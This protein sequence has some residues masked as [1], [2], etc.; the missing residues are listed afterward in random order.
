[1]TETASSVLT[2]WSNFYIMIGSAAASLTGLMFVVITLVMGTERTRKAEDGI[3]T[4]STP[5]V[6]H[7]GA[8]LLV[9][10]VLSA[11]WHLLLH[12][13]ILLGLLGTCGV[14]YLLRIMY[15]T[16]RLTAYNPDVED[17][18]WY[19]I[20]PFVA[21]AVIFAGAVILPLVPAQSLFVLALGT[22]LLIFIGI[23]N[24]WDIVTYIALGGVSEPPKSE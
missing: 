2:P 3:S 12:P 14:V 6:M 20:L 21:Y 13:A 24:A 1:M 15:R 18:A 19:S 17:W 23:H 22:A 11:P 9:S 7:F 16:K 5:T 4:F 10:A 8:A